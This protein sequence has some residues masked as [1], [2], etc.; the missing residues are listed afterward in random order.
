MDPA[1]LAL[2]PAPADP[3]SA[4]QFPPVD[5]RTWTLPNG[6]GL[7]VQEDHSAPVASVQVWVETGSIHEDR[8]LGAGLSH[9]L[10]HMLFKGTKT[11]G[12]SEFAQRIQ[13]AGGYINA[14]TSFDRTVYWIDIPSKGVPTA[15]ELLTDAVMNSTLPP[16][17]Y[18]KEQEVIRREFAMGYDDPDRMSGHALFAQ[19]YREHPY[20]HPII[21]HLDVF[22][23]LHRDDVMAY[24]RA[25]YAPNNM[26]FV[27]VGDLEPE[28]VHQQLTALFAEHPR[29]SVTPVF[30]P[31]EPAQL[32]R[33]ESHVEFA[34]EL[35]RLNI[36]WHIP[37]LTHPDVPALDVLAVVLGSGRSS[38]MYKRLRE[39][40]GLV[41]SIDA[42]C[43]APG[44]PGLFGV[45]AVLDPEKRALVEAE[46]LA[47]LEE[48]RSSGISVAELEK[49][50]RMALSHQL[51][52]VTTMRG[53]A[54]DL[55]SNWLL[56]R[57]LDFSRDYLAAIQ[58]V[59]VADITRVLAQYCT[60][61]NLTITS[62]N[63]IGSLT[64]TSEKVSAAVTGEIQ[65]FE[66]SNGLRLLVRED[67][68]LPL[69]S[70]GA[71]F[72]CGLLVETPEDNG[73]GRL[74]SKVLL[75]GTR[76]RTAEQLADEIE[77][78][79]GAISSDAGNNSIN[80]FVRVLQPDLRLGLD[81]LADTLLHSSLP[82]KA[83]AREKEIQ[84]AGI[85]AEEEEMT[86]VAR[87]LLR[88]E[89]YP[90]H[91]YGLKPLG[92]PESVARL[93][94][95]DLVAFRDQ[96]L[97]ARN[98]VLAVF[99]NVKAAEV[100]ALVEEA[101]ATLPAGEL[102][103]TTVPQPVPITAGR[104]VKRTKD[105]QQAVLMT[106]YHCVDLYSPD[107]AA[108]EL[109]DEASSD[110]GSRFFLRIREEMGLAYF[111]GSSQMIGL[112]RGPFVFYCGTDPAKVDEVKAALHDEIRK[113]AEHGLT[114]AELARAK[115]K[116]LGAQ[117]IRNQS[118]D[119]FAFSCAL[120]ELYGLGFA[121]YRTLRAQI[122]AV[123]LD[124]VRHVAR[125][126]FLD[127][128]AITAIVHP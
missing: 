59:T 48:I 76:T 26:F 68:R 87:Q 53:R 6:L 102:A 75:K 120:D 100:R 105:K 1:T 78:V 62:L 25:R 64:A 96:Y 90:N 11:R 77:A 12:A 118:N 33:R 51:S 107:R 24:Y 41:H 45:D 42:W 73:I 124:E 61:G 20:R 37:E 58:R 108:L 112:A 121:H 113:L 116:F 88:A 56:T 2:A 18:V 30:I 92:S 79:G 126:Y 86:V 65:K 29:R 99:G 55:G 119:S 54:S 103:L 82:E 19:A 35:T 98:G 89:L 69:V 84:L 93:T 39:D 127:Q 111:V 71:S 38:R 32:G 63:P 17:E 70:I 72:K 3:S 43:Y 16:E 91:P 5:A 10:E 104:E 21:G 85:K 31:E 117:D 125:K 8:H 81:I 106:G 74:L 128:P 57:N 122:E 4:I 109:I 94:R 95:D 9:I 110:L 114:A 47:M 23:G 49:A 44:Q 22:N 13:D 83:I 14:Y 36:A 101:L 123:T 27:V 46:V 50:K 60:D 28:A 115:E 15:L 7:I 67:A 34:T 66:L 97:V 80:V 52:A 40:A